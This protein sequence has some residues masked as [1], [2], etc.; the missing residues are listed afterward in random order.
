MRLPDVTVP[1]QTT[2]SNYRP[3]VAQANANKFFSIYASLA[4]DIK[5][6]NHR[7][8][9]FLRYPFAKITSHPPQVCQFYPTFVVR[10]KQRERSQYFFSWIS[11]K[12]TLCGEIEESCS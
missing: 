12:H 3:S 2:P 9:F 5:L 8:H 10:V 1:F 4:K 7:C 6:L 11:S